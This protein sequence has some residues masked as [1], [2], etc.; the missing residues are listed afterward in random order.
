[1]RI[2]RVHN[3]YQERGGED[4]SFDTEVQ[5]LRERGEEVHSLLF[6][7]DDI[8][9]QRSHR[10]SL[11]LALSTVWSRSG[12]D[13]VASTVKSFRP[14]VVHFDNTF[15]LV[16]PAAYSACR[17]SGAAVVQSLRNYRL[18]CPSA[19]FFRDG[20][21]CEDCLGKPIPLPG[22]IHSCYR[23]SRAQT[24]V[25]ASMNT[26]HRLRGTWRKDVD[27]FITLTAFSRNK[28]V[29]GGLPSDRIVVK[30]NFVHVPHDA[31]TKQP[32]GFLFVGRLTPEKGINTLLSA[33]QSVGGLPL[34]I[35]G[36]GPLQKAVESVA[37]SFPSVELLGRLSSEQTYSRMRDAQALIFPSEWYETFGRVAIEAF[38][39]STP[40]IAASI[41]A[42]AELVQDGETGLLFEPGNMLELSA[43][44]RWA[45]EHPGDMRRM[46]ENAR[47]TYEARYTP[48]RNYDLLMDIYQQAIHHSD[49]V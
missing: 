33:W 16:S 11:N 43:K 22:V 10:E 14:D 23:H 42:I 30:P 38:A 29:E 19:T 17:E 48:E 24:S 27:R 49:R 9:E 46:G 6:S 39:Q 8:A 5:L 26:F 1:M 3:R 7:N 36:D 15:P 13:R 47:M 20:H 44:V 21:V 41:G 25:I 45:A 12:K 28:F 32:S 4:V 40:V 35:I 2:L 37:A 18:L 34:Q 31:S